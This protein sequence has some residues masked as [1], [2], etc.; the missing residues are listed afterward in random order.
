[1][2]PELNKLLEEIK[3]IVEKK[4]NMK[5]TVKPQKRLDE[6][7]NE[8]LAAVMKEYDVDEETAVEIIMDFAEN[9]EK[10]KLHDYPD[11]PTEKSNE[12]QFAIWVNHAQKYDFKG[13]VLK[14]FEKLAKVQEP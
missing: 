10:N 5:T 2:K 12:A 1:M 8:V 6:Y 3:S 11:F 4:P 7:M 13:N 9:L 14:H